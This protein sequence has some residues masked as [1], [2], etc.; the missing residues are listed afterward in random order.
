MNIIIL[1]LSYHCCL[2]FSFL[3]V[4]L[5]VFSLLHLLLFFRFFLSPF[6][7][8]YIFIL[9]LLLSFGFSL[10]LYFSTHFPTLA[11]VQA[12]HS[13]PLCHLC[14]LLHFLL[15]SL[16]TEWIEMVVGFFDW[17]IV[18]WKLFVCLKCFEESWCLSMYIHAYI[19]CI[20]I[21]ITISVGLP[22]AFSFCSWYYICYWIW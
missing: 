1:F 7:N 14:S 21:Y 20:N 15:E 5:N 17:L 19:L 16:G 4:Q 18:A 6:S 2:N 11:P 9:K 13:G 3:S 22:A 12:Q 10:Q 8:E